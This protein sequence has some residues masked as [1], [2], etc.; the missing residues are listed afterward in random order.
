M[1]NTRMARVNGEAGRYTVVD[2][3]ERDGPICHICTDP[4]DMAL[5]GND[6]AGP[7]VDHII[8]ISRGGPDVFDNVA[9]AHRYCNCCRGARDLDEV[10]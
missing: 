6:I 5:S 3:A 10:A 7:T 8:P 9:L 1:V 2:I 4:I